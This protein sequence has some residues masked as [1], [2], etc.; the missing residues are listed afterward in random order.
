[1][2]RNYLILSLLKF[3]LT[4]RLLYRVVGKSSVS[5]SCSSVVFLGATQS[6]NESFNNLIWKYCP[7]TDF[8]GLVSVQMAIYLATLTF[9]EGMHLRGLVGRE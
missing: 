2:T 8:S 7:K 5:Q 6:Q 3:R 1:M 4:K 9:N